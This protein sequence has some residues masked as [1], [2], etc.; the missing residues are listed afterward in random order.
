MRMRSMNGTLEKMC[1]T[2]VFSRHWLSRELPPGGIF[3]Y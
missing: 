2:N 1:L 3:Y